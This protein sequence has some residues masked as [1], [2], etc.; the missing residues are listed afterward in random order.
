MAKIRIEFFRSFG[1]GIGSLFG[2]WVLG[3]G[4]L[5]VWTL[6]ALRHALRPS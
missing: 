2:I 4:I 1:I 6:R 5:I 3:F